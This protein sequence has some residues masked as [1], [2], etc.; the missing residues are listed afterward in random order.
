MSNV[1]DLKKQIA[2]A[3]KKFTA[4]A[5]LVNSNKLQTV[6]NICLR[7]EGTAKRL[8]RATYTAYSYTNPVTGNLVVNKRPRSIP[9]AAPAP[10]NGMLMRSI[11]H[12]TEV[13]FS[14][15]FG[16]V[17]STITNPPYGS[18][19]ENGTTKMAP[20]PWLLPAVDAIKRKTR[21]MFVAALESDRAIVEVSASD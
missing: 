4:K 8:M 18:Y 6:T 10:D 3:Q 12:N 19:L 13:H 5:A 14:E 11:T 2:D 17:G 7:I 15:A 16:R 1:D 20:R 9:D 21:G